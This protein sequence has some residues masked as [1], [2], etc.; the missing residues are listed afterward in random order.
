MER[1]ESFLS[2]RSFL[3]PQSIDDRIFFISNL[4]GQLSLYAMNFGG[5]VPEP[6]LPADIALQNPHL[7]G[8]YSFYLFPNLGNILVMIDQDG[9]E[10]YKPMLIS[11]HGG[12]P[13]PI[14]ENQFLDYRTNISHCDPESNIVYISAESLKEPIY[15]S[16]QFNLETR[17]L[18]FLAKSEWG[19][20]VAG[21]GD[22][23]KQVV[24]LDPY[25]F[26]DHVGYLWEESHPE[27]RQLFGVPLEERKEGQKVDPN[28]IMDT[29][30]TPQGGLLFTTALFQDTYGLGYFPL[31]DPKS[32]QEVSIKG[33]QHS[34]AGEMEGL[35]HNKGYRYSLTYNIDGS[36]WL[37]EGQFYEDD[38]QMQV[39]KV[40]CGD[41]HLSDGVVE[42]YHF[43][44][45]SDRYIISFSTATSP[46]QI[47]SVVGSDQREVY[48]HTNERILGLDSEDLS[49]GE[50]ASFVS[51]DGTRISARLYLPNAARGFEAPFPVVYYI[52]GGP[53]SQERPDFSW[54]SMPLIQF[55]TLKGLAVFVPNVRG[56]TGYGMSYMKQVDRDWGGKDRLDHVYAMEHIL[57][58]DERLDVARSGLVG[59]SYGGYMTLLLAGRHAKLWS[60]AVDM[61]GPY[62]LL[63][64]LDRIPETWKPYFSISLGDPVDDRDFLFERSP[65]TYLDNLSCP[66][67]VIQGKND[68]RVV[69]KESRDLVD[70]LNAEGKNIDYLVFENEGHD[71]LKYENRVKCYNSI[72]DFFVNN[73]KPSL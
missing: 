51:F 26:G 50:D 21:V 40:I 25:T 64:F 11:L 7:V 14:L 49:P 60:A 35:R 9:D 45:H 31:S 36:S 8:G 34:G 65:K 39:D 3:A 18:K 15:E 30:F 46:S 48:Q 29:C 58:G 22:D 68:P 62:D 72:T 44:K 43:D 4:S 61:F 69:E 27:L 52:H 71:I 55:L 5:S 63:T 20:H 47:I 1:I 28:G 24:I 57:P 53:Q 10:V 59:R 12:Y 42:D 66:M 54:F 13:E 37:Y 33:L 16:Y 32:I 56:S 67:L 38:C 41:G 17:M 19:A 70:R 2:A 73:L 23:H 6:L